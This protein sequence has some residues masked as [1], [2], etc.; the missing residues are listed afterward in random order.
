[1][2]TVCGA[3]P[4]KR[5]MRFSDITNIRTT[6]YTLEKVISA[7]LYGRK[8]SIAEKHYAPHVTVYTGFVHE[9]MK[10]FAHQP[11]VCEPLQSTWNIM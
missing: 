1:M 11:R 9:L 5:R 3:A 10:F 2:I 6:K 8:N 7:G 4:V